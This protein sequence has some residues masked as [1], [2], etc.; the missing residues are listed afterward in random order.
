MSGPAIDPKTGEFMQ[1]GPCPVSPK[2][3][4]RICPPTSEIDCLVVEKVFD[5]C[6]KEDIIVREFVI[7]AGRGGACA[8]VDLT[9][10]NRVECDVLNAECVVVD[11]TPPFEDNTRIVTL[12][13][14]VEVKIELWHDPVLWTQLPVGSQGGGHYS[15]PVLL[16]TFTETISNSYN[17]VLLYVPPSGVLFGAA[18]G[19]FL[20]CEVVASTC[21]C[22]PET[23]AP[24]EPVTQVICTVKVCKIV[25]VTA[26]VK[27]MIP[28]YGYCVPRP[29][30]AAPQQK[31]IECPP[32]Y[33]LFPPQQPIPPTSEKIKRSSNTEGYGESKENDE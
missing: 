23:V 22:T 32:I 30:E 12:K 29:C 24:G 2:G 17:Q 16:C 26:F 33:S 4:L 15:K 11:V 28:L 21:Y 1:P 14:N 31:E 19:P 6:F 25:E 9:R 7:P 10:V 8:D 13:Q 5:Q 3:G 20:F 18:G 27:I